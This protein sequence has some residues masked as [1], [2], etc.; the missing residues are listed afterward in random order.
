MFHGSACVGEDIWNLWKTKKT[1][2][3]KHV[4]WWWIPNHAKTWGEVY[5]VIISVD[6]CYC[7]VHFFMPDFWNLEIQDILDLFGKSRNPHTWSKMWVAVFRVAFKSPFQQVILWFVLLH[8]SIFVGRFD[9]LLGVEL[10][11]WVVNFKY[12]FP[13]KLSALESAS[14]VSQHET[15]EMSNFKSWFAGN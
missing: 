15:I 12:K 1:T 10:Y 8:F 7:C 6:W 14:G 13:S 11:S 9:F 4:F 5:P 2:S 3:T